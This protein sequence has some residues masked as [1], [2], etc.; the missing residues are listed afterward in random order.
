V[1]A[2]ALPRN[3]SASRPWII[4]VGS[5]A[6]I[7]A[8]GAVLWWPVAPRPNPDELVLYCAAG[9]LKPVE[10]IVA[11]YQQEC[12][13][14]VRI[15]PG[16]S[17]TLLSKLRVTPKAADLYLAAEESYVREARSLGLVAEIIPVARMHVVI[18][19]KQGN[20]LKI[21][22]PD[23]LLR[24][25]V[26]V[27]IPN[28]ELA[29]VGRTV[30]RVLTGTGQWERLIQRTRQSSAKVS[31]VGTV[32]E[33]A[34]ALKI[35]AA[36]AA[37][38][39]DATARQ[40]GVEFVELPDFKEKASEQVHLGVVA[41][42]ERPTA[43]LHFAR[44]LAAGDRGE[45]RFAENFFEPL[46]DADAWE[47]RP[48]LVLMSGAMLKPAIDDLVK[49]FSQRE[50]VDVN[51]IYAGCGIHVAQMK[52]IR[53]GDVVATHFPDAYFACD[54]SFM[55]MVQQW[56]EASKTISRN[57][58]VLA[59]PKGNPLGIK[60]IKDLTRPELRLGLAHP[61]NSALGAL[62][63]DLLKKLG[64]HEQVYTPKRK[65]PVVH[66]DAGHM[67]V[68]QMRAGALD[69]I[70]VYR[71]NVLSNTDNPDRALEIVEMNIPEAIAIQPYA[72]A[73][74]S[75]HKYLMRRFLDAILSP[76]SESHFR[77]VG[78]QWIAEKQGPR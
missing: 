24:E 14:T 39:W 55:K 41:A 75:Q 60:S 46:A 26:A 1:K 64:L 49:R 11:Q 76:Q 58:M 43:A 22:E 28:P 62:T 37:I 13:A 67:L 4:V 27:V 30:Q 51:T 31:L 52:A 78:F 45:K 42:S 44:Y 54:V 5:L 3:G 33:A 74:D 69:I 40:Y 70:V 73:K 77:D 10:A 38:V 6:A 61:V 16:G 68:N 12:G 34:Q 9:L 25:D 8:L 48:Q 19:V 63:D 66:T 36:D 2:R 21:A 17:G 53:K 71:S 20:P 59:V 23:D 18:A 50:G 72:V 47:D 35:G 32:N 65:L 57:D 29:A 15:E 7:A 56:F